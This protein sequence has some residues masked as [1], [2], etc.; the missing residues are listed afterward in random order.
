MSV[1]ETVKKVAKYVRDV[2]QKLY[3]ITLEVKINQG[4]KYVAWNT[5]WSELCK[6]YPSSTYE[7]HCDKDGLPFFDS[8]IGLFVKVSVTVEGITHTMTRPVYN[9][10]MK[11]M[12][13]FTYEY[14][15]KQG[16]RQVEGATAGDVNDSIMRCLVKAIAMHGLGLYVYEDKPFADLETINSEEISTISK[17]IVQNNLSLGDLNKVFGINKLSELASYNFD[18][19]IEWIKD[20]AINPR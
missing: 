6:K 9:K 2:F 5:A 14:T 16:T 20:N 18:S 17:L 4:R 19:A 3:S 11:A 15:T 12:K 10:A 1:K 13:A 7:I 8:P